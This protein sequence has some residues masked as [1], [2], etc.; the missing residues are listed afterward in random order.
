MIG[1]G[2][3]GGARLLFSRSPGAKAKVT[4]N[5]RSVSRLAMSAKNNVCDFSSYTFQMRKPSRSLTV[6]LIML[7]INAQLWASGSEAFADWLQHEHLQF[8]AMASGA[9][10]DGAGC[11][12][13]CNEGCYALQHLQ[14]SAPYYLYH[15]VFSSASCIASRDR[16]L[17]L[18]SF[19]DSLF[20]PPRPLP[21][22]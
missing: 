14:S 15:V 9:H 16:A 1:D 6:L 5:P 19:L 18:P 4:S 8:L 11:C 22:R 2:S 3:I 20:R 12:K 21:A 10:D 7:V 17:P 13:T